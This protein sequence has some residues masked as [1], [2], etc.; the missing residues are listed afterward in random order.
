MPVQGPTCGV[1]C[2]GGLGRWLK[3]SIN[4]KKLPFSPTTTH[5]LSHLV[6]PLRG[7]DLGVHARDVDAGVEAGFVVS[8]DDV[9]PDGGARA[10]RAVVGALG[11][12]VAGR[13]PPQ[14]PLGV[15]VEQGVFLLDAEPGLLGGGLSVCVGG[16]GRGCWFW[17]GGR[18][19]FPHTHT[20]TPLSLSPSP[21]PWPSRPPPACWWGSASAAPRAPRRATAAHTRRT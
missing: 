21:S 15:S 7:H 11:A 9:A 10:G 4:K 17:V 18:A 12:G 6:L 3:T 13:G 8:L 5:P 20:H 19:L 14:R 2:G 1:V 16:G